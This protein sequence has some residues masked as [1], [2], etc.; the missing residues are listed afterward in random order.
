MRLAGARVLLTGAD[1]GIGRVLAPRLAARGAD[2]V[3]TGLDPDRLA[4]QAADL[5]CEHVPWTLGSAADAFALGDKVGPVD[6]VVHGAGLGHR[7][8]VE[9]MTVERIDEL[10]TLDLTVPIALTRAVLPAMLDRGRGH[11]CFVGSIAGQVAVAE[12]AAYAA[13]KGGLALFADSL[14]LEVVHRGVEVSVV[15]PAA[16]DTEF[17]AHRGVPYHRRRPAPMAPEVVAG[18]VVRAVERSVPVTVLPRW[19][20]LAVAVRAVAPRLYDRLAGRFDD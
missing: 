5:R 19:M 8:P 15:A 7:G 14:R 1:G 18:A 3:L 17:F 9:D 2:L 4:A 16:V 10:V 11:V 20:A 12:E 13:A 6:V